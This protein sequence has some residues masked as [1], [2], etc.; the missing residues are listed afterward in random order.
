M[1]MSASEDRRLADEMRKSEPLPHRG[2]AGALSSGSP[3]AVH[4]DVAMPQKPLS[5][6]AGETDTLRRKRLL[7]AAAFLAAVN[8]V[9]TFWLL[10][11]DDP[12][13]FTA[14]GGLFSLRVGLSGVRCLLAAAVAACWPARC[15]SSAS[16][17]APSSTG[18]SWA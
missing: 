2:P 3:S 1:A 6:S 4:P 12:G 15:R 8:A 5:S 14:A 10:V 7:A 11:S 13:T 17:S 16:S 18:C 9:V